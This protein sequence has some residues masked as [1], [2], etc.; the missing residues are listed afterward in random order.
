MKSVRF[1]K[2]SS[3]L[4]FFAIFFAGSLVSSTFEW[5]QPITTVEITNRSDLTIDRIE[6]KFGGQGEFQGVLRD[7]LAPGKTVAFKWVTHSESVYS[8]RANFS[9]GTAIVGGAGYTE[10]GRTIA[11]SISK[12]KV[13]STESDFPFMSSTRETTY[14]APKAK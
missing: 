9:D 3:Q 6:I 8:L 2:F 11:E 4:K 1:P 5:L 14:R 7:G 13:M 10:R 12:D